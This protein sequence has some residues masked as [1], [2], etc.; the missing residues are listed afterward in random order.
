MNDWMKNIPDNFLLY[1]INLPGSHDSCAKKVRFSYFSKCHDLSIYEQLNIGIRF[2]DIRLEKDGNKLKT[3][4]GFAQCYKEG[5]GKNPLYLDDVLRDCKTFL[6]GNPSETIIMCIKR[7][8]GASSE[9]TF[10]TFYENYLN[11]D[12]IWYK[13]NR[14]PTLGE[15]RGKIVLVNRCCVDNE[16]G[17]YTD[18]DT[19]INFSGWP[20]QPKLIPEGFSV[21]PIPRRDGNATDRYFVQ[22][23]YKLSPK[24]KWEK[25]VLPMLKNPPEETGFIFNFFSAVTPLTPPRRSAK[26]IF[27]R[28]SKY[29]LVP[30]RKYGWFIMDFPTEKLCRKII[31][32]N[33]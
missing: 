3:V 19:G 32:T 20:H 9:E 23:M 29:D 8:N 2:L 25:G 18:Y 21:V 33:F 12:T 4:H 6:K 10:D 15:V 27:K 16:D 11:G 17:F 31:L 26:Y 7:D 13:E 24:A 30:F 1:D 28:F 5:K 22:D 14:I